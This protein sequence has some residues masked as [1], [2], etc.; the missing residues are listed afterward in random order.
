MNWFR[1][2]F[3]KPKHATLLAALWT[4]YRPVSSDFLVN[5]VLND[6][7]DVA[8]RDEIDPGSHGWLIGDAMQKLEPLRGKLT[9]ITSP[10]VSVADD[11]PDGAW[12]WHYVTPYTVGSTGPCIQHAKLWLFHWQTPQGEEIQVTV[13]STNLTREAFNRQ[14]QAGWSITLPVANC[15]HGKPPNPLIDLLR[16]LGK[17]ARCEKRTDYWIDLIGKIAFPKD[18]RLIASIP[19]DPSPLTDW[20]LTKSNKIWIMVPSIG[21]WDLQSLD[22]WRKATCKRRGE[23]CLVLPAKNHCWSA[24]HDNEGETSWTIPAATA[25]PFLKSKGSGLSIRKMPDP[26]VFTGGKQ[27]D[28]RWGHTKL[29]GFDNGLLVGSHNWSPSAWGVPGYKKSMVSPRNFELSVFIAGARMP[30]DLRMG[31]LKKDEIVISQDQ[32]SNTSHWVV[33]AQAQWD[34]HNLC[35]EWVARSDA[36]RV[37]LGWFNGHQWQPVPSKDG[38]T[39]C[40]PMV[41]RDMELAPRAVR[42]YR[43]G[44][45]DDAVSIPVAD[46]REGAGLLPAGQSGSVLEIRDRL[47][48]ESYGGIAFIH[49]S[50][51]R[52]KVRRNTEPS[53]AAGEDYRP[54]WIVSCRNWSRVVDCWREKFKGKIDARATGEAIRIADAIERISGVEDIGARIAAQELRTLSRE[55]ND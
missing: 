30:C 45:E 39:A 9:V 40:V 13:S 4:S 24:Q 6:L 5:H 8:P 34:G 52:Q 54:R 49:R 27:N 10:P 41:I 15:P 23:V 1:P 22:S 46:L 21:Q 38:R 55:K 18:V 17:S 28:P 37:V 48:L 44:A 3:E 50:G 51:A 2:V 32:I 36:G 25:A 16:G 14:I 53:P 35:I 33:W 43:K 19:G 42:L 20:P 31:E 26:P 11:H 29:Y 7:L 47:L 12:L